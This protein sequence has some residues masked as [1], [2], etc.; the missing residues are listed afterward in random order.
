M[1]GY[2]CT[3]IAVVMAMMAT[4][5]L[6][7]TSLAAGTVLSRRTGGGCTLPYDWRGQ[8]YQSGLGDVTIEQTTISDIGTCVERKDDFFVLEDKIRNC[9]Q[10]L[11]LI[12]PHK[13]ILQYKQGYC[14]QYDTLKQVCAHIRSEMP[15][16]TLVR[17]DS[18]AVPC[19]FSEA[20]TFAY[21]NNSNGFCRDPASTARPCANDGKYKFHFRQCHGVSDTF[22]KELDFH[23][24]ATWKANSE[25][26]VYGSFTGSGIVKRDDMYRC[27]KYELL[28]NEVHVSMSADASCRGLVSARDGPV[29]LEFSRDMAMWPESKCSLPPWLNKGTWRDLSG[30]HTYDLSRDSRGLRVSYTPVVSDTPATVASLRCVDV[31]KENKHSVIVT[32]HAVHECNSF[33][34]CVRIRALSSDV[35]EIT[36]GNSKSIQRTNV[37]CDASDFENRT[38]RIIFPE[39]LTPQA[40]P[41]VEGIFTSQSAL[42]RTKCTRTVTGCNVTSLLRFDSNCLDDDGV[43]LTCLSHWSTSNKLNVIAQIHDVHESRTH[44]NCFMFENGPEGFRFQVDASCNHGTDEILDRSYQD[45][46]YPTKTAC[47]VAGDAADRPEAQGSASSRGTPSLHLQRSHHFISIILLL[48]ASLAIVRWQTLSVVTS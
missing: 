21:N 39:S 44:A 38:R 37:E 15:L 22:N 33:Y 11:L 24:L 4:V 19:P 23:C 3:R 8:W 36:Q 25:T 5:V 42:G 18:R 10:C 43:T 28:G 14:V 17:D 41:I 7:L 34:Q 30:H 20:F 45:I 6:L 40:C 32:A 16:F 35:L 47:R 9:R 2:K 12:H 13:N 26:F 31:S 1:H 29:V 27:L 48:L 46:A